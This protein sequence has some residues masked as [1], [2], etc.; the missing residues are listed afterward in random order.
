MNE[1][2]L[3]AEIIGGGLR[4]IKDVNCDWGMD[5]HW[6]LVTD[7]KE[8]LGWIMKLIKAT[9]G[10]SENGTERERPWE[11]LLDLKNMEEFGSEQ[12]C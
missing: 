5:R 1:Q 6:I 11:V 2:I 7:R 10:K 8:D 9:R 12:W 3:L 4:K